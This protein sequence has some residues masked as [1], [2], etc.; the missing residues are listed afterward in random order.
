MAEIAG[1]LQKTRSRNL[2]IGGSDGS[3][4]HYNG[5]VFSSMRSGSRVSAVTDLEFHHRETQD[6]NVI[7]A[8]TY[9]AG[10]Y[11]SPDQA[12]NWLNL[13]TPDYYVHAISTSSLCAA[14]QGELL[15]CT[16]TGL[17]AG[18][19][20]DALSHD[21][22]HSATVFNDLGIKTISVNGGYMMVSPSGICAVTA[23]AD[24]YATETVSDITVYGEDVT[25]R[26]IAMQSG[27]VSDP[28]VTSDGTESAGGGSGCFIST[29]Q[30]AGLLWRNR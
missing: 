20:R 6:I 17:I 7:Y 18:Q 24:A 30:P 15:Q 4:I 11:I 2:F 28:S 10:I 13:G 16:G 26:N 27:V 23:I 21:G 8:G 14:T 25:W 19:V 5:K 3:I 9:G 22:I 29:T 1:R 12:D